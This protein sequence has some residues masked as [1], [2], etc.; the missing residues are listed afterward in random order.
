MNLI[1]RI[2]RWMVRNAGTDA[3]IK[4]LEKQISQLDVRMTA[5]ETRDK[6][7][8]RSAN[9]KDSLTNLISEYLYGEE[10]RR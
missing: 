8:G 9:A 7:D 2:C 6:F 5:I 10:N 3:Y 1:K 4:R